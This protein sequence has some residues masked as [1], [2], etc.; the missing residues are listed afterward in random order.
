MLVSWGS[1]VN[2]PENRPFCAAMAIV[3]LLTY[4]IADIERISAHF[5]EREI[6]PDCE[7]TRSVLIVADHA[8]PY[9]P[10]APAFLASA[11]TPRI[12]KSMPP[13]P[14][15]P[16]VRIEHTSNGYKKSAED[17]FANLPKHPEPDA[18]MLIKKQHGRQ[19]RRD[20]FRARKRR[21]LDSEKMRK[22]IGPLWS[23]HRAKMDGE[24]AA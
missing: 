19:R 4:T 11:P 13:I 23:N 8:F 21:A 7:A 10:S 22:Q 3:G 2:S 12:I 5:D 17:W 16:Y 15:G 24:E 20:G 6:V 9:Q 14:L 1:G 18:E